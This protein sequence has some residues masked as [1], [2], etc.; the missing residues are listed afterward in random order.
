ML[1]NNVIL[2]LRRVFLFVLIMVGILVIAGCD[3]KSEELVPDELVSIEEVPEDGVSEDPVIEE[4]DSEEIVTNFINSINSKDAD[5]AISLLS[6]DINFKF[7]EQDNIIGKEKVQAWLPEMFGQNLKLEVG[8]SDVSDNVVVLQTSATWTKL[9][10]WHTKELTGSTEVSLESG[11]ISVFD[12][13]LDEE[14]LSML[15]AP[16]TNFSD[17]IGIWQ[18]AKPHPA[19]GNIFLQLNSDGMYR[20]STD[21]AERLDTTPMVEGKYQ[22]DSGKIFRTN[23]IQLVANYLWDCEDSTTGEYNVS[24]LA[25]GNIIFEVVKDE[26]RGREDTFGSEYV[27]VQ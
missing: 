10:V 18:R 27:F 16:V 5:T 26:C 2:N 21:T 7:G 1:V 20:Q 9:Q 3:T 13:K 6:E 25:N 12:F 8:E 11:K 15:P 24:R 17:L 4:V 19:I 14:S 23:E 22:F